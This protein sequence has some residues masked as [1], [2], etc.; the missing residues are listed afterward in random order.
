[1]S[2]ATL[3]GPVI[4]WASDHHD[5]HTYTDTDKDPHAG[6]LFIGIGR[7][8]QQQMTFCINSW[9]HFVGDQQYT[10]GTPRDSWGIALFLLG[11]NWHNFHH[12]FPSDYRNGDKWYHF[13][14]HKW[15]IFLMSKVGL[16]WD[17]Q[18]TSKERISAKMNLTQEQF[19]KNT[20]E[21]WENIK[22]KSVDLVDLLYSHYKKI[23]TSKQKFTDTVSSSISS[24]Y[25]DLK[26]KLDSLIE[27]ATNSCE[28]PEESTEKMLKRAQASLEKIEVYVHKILCNNHNIA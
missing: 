5:H 26:V 16:A 23:E 28:M 3:Q 27:I 20:V 10:S 6:F 21:S 24:T 8:I 18:M 13:D 4:A 11:E 7:A 12:A 2:A 25:Y 17:L 14:V 9:T 15:I 1:M 19:R 22:V